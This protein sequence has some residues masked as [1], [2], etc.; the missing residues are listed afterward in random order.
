MAGLQRKEQKA[1]LKDL[2]AQG[3][4]IE[5]TRGG[6]LIY[7]PNG[8]GIVCFHKSA[9]DNRSTLNLRAELRRAGLSWPFDQNQ[10]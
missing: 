10:S 9:S 2:E 7:S 1:L 6:W 8:K 4:R 3:A 5:T